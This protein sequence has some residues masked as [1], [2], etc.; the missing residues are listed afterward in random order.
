MEEKP[1]R[2]IMKVWKDYT[3][4]DAIIVIEKAVKAVKSETVNSCWRDCIQMLYDFTWL[5]IEPIKKIMKGIEDRAK[6]LVK[7][8]R[9]FKIWMLEKFKSWLTQQMN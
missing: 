1:D 7:W 6:K 9:C 8:V 3:I 5:T 2:E 4:E